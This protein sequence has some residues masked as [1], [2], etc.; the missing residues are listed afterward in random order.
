MPSPS[1]EFL[2]SRETDR[3]PTREFPS[4]FPEDFVC[5]LD[6]K[7]IIQVVILWRRRLLLRCLPLDH[8]VT[9]LPFSAVRV[10]EK[11]H[12]PSTSIRAGLPGL[13]ATR[14]LLL[15]SSSQW[16]GQPDGC[17][18]GLAA[19]CPG[20]TDWGLLTD[21]LSET[22]LG[23]RHP[24]THQQKTQKHRCLSIC[25]D[26]SKRA[27][28]CPQALLGACQTLQAAV[29]SGPLSCPPRRER[30]HWQNQLP[31]LLLLTVAHPHCCIH[32]LRFM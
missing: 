31:L 6:R 26:Q 18:W 9:L 16:L 27:G 29:P 4:R 19:H 11:I 8:L 13:C 5:R 30:L 20:D 22:G 28:P 17:Q 1:H 21:G 14:D 10:T 25:L 23:P 32:Y 7:A 15:A 2:D 12:S 3:L 24:P